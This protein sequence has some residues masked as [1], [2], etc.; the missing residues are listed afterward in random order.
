MWTDLVLSYEVPSETKVTKIVA[1]RL[2]F[3][4]FKA[5]E[6]EKVNGTFTRLK[7]LLN[8]IENNS[9]SIPQ[10]EVNATSLKKIVHQP[11]PSYPSSNKTYSKPK[12]QS[13][14]TPQHYQRVDNY[15]KDYKRKCKGLKAEIAIHTKKIDSL[16][17]G[18][19]K[20]GLIA[21]LFDWDEELVSSEDERVTKVKAFMAIVEEEPF[22][23][24]ND[25][26]LG[27][28]VEITMKKV[29]RL[30]FMTDGDERKHVLDYAYVYLHYVEDQRKTLLSK[31]N[32]LNQELSSCMSELDDLKNTKALN[33]SLQNEIARLNLENESQRDE[34]FDLKKVI[35]KW[36]SSKVTLDQLLIEQVPVPE[37]TSDSDSES[38]N[39]EPLPPL[40]KLLGAEPSVTSKDVISLADLTLTP[41]VSE[42]IKKVP[43][44]RSM[45]KVLKK[46]A[47]PVTS[48]VPDLSLVKKADSSTEKLLL[49][50]M[51]ESL[52]P[53]IGDVNVDDSIDKSS[54]KTSVQPVTQ[55]K[56]KP[57]KKLR[58]KKIL[59][60]SEPKASKIVKESSPSP[61]VTDTQ[62]AEEI[63]A[64]ANATH[65]LE[66]SELVEEQG[67]Q[68]K[69]ADTTKCPDIGLDTPY[70]ARLIQPIGLDSLECALRSQSISDIIPNL[71]DLLYLR[72]VIFMDMAYVD[73]R[74]TPYWEL[75]K[76]VFL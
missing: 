37:I 29:Q 76:R 50:L 59:V 53:P 3:N 66:A 33:C 2:K 43:D 14:S 32:S 25:A 51:E 58:R 52:F 17:K 68:P 48:F 26:I 39:Q 4:A 56:E 36:T 60:S 61:Q 1:L 18:K 35:K 16:S 8:D 28:W 38:N 21:E 10:A 9:V 70:L 5:L 31:Y 42:E 57:D 73:R 63:V 20:K 65:S 71:L 64:T 12:F 55:P 62:H 24:K 6:G 30:L 54:S 27:Q 7:C 41:T 75:V 44:K 15:Q 34:I 13:N 49:T 40:P 72:I 46:K 47:Q 19:S 74:D 67:N 45:V 23:G 11:T 69:T 22:V